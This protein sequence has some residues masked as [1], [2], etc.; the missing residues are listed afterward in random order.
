M[1]LETIAATEAA[2]HSRT[3]CE[4]EVLDMRARMLA[5]RDTDEGT[6][7]TVATLLFSIGDE[8]YGVRLA[9]V[10]EIH[11]EYHLTPLPCVP[12][13]VLGVVSIRGEVLSVN[14]LARMMGLIGSCPAPHGGQSP[15]IVL[16]AGEVQAAIVVDDIGDIAD[17][18]T[19]SIDAPLSMVGHAQAPFL[20]GTVLVEGR[21]VGL[22]DATRVLEPVGGPAKR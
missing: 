4:R 15:A 1:T 8:T 12:D 16:Q 9:D 14:D 19:E 11:R 7:E 2:G 5:E 17:I 3:A 10:R 13:S 20:S 6:R 22:I 21:L 18:P